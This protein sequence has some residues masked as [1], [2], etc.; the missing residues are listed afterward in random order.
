MPEQQGAHAPSRLTK[1][2]PIL[3][4]IGGYDRS[5]LGL[6]L[7]AG[8]TVWGLIVPEG[9]AYASLAGLPAQAGLYTILVSLLAYAVLGFV[10]TVGR[11][12]HLCDGRARR[13]D[14]AGPEPG[15]RRGVRG[16]RG[17]TR[18]A[19]CCSCSPGSPGWGSSRSS[20]RGR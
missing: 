14:G 17:W 7:V 11:L 16:L 1:Y 3:G 2:V 15:G 5:W 8:L 18:A 4:W 19:A 9:I 10:A 6:D 13:I 12:R 20:C